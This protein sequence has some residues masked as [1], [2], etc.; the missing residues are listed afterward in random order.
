[1]YNKFA[2]SQ[3]QGGE[4]MSTIADRIKMLREN[5]GLTQDEFGKLFGIVKSTVSL[6]E[7]GKSTPNDQIKTAICKHF[8]VSLDY[9][10]GLSNDSGK[11]RKS[12]NHLNVEQGD[13]IIKQT[14][15][16]TGLLE[17]DGTLSDIGGKVISDFIT[18]NADI[19]KK[20]MNK[21]T[22]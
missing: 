15:K 2:I 7:H 21:E 14:L 6:Y 22:D 10:I 16:D 3:L 4:K 9:L 8:N 11:D 1:M 19:L 20:L 12:K 18:K 13:L 5:E 17:P